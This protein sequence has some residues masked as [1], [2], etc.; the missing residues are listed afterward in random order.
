MYYMLTTATEALHIL[1]AAILHT[2]I[3]RQWPLP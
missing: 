1:F 2:L 3:P